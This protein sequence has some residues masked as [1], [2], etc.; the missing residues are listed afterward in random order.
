MY[1]GTYKFIF[2]HKLQSQASLILSGFNPFIRFLTLFIHIHNT[3]LQFLR[4]YFTIINLAQTF[5][6]ISLPGKDIRVQGRFISEPSGLKEIGTFVNRSERPDRDSD[7]ARDIEQWIEQG[8]HTH[9]RRIPDRIWPEK[10]QDHIGALSGSP[11]AQG[12]SEVFLTFR[13]PECS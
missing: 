13:D 3:L 12:L 11:N 9:T 10:R 5:L 2:N 4:R 8:A 7:Y 6:P 1:V